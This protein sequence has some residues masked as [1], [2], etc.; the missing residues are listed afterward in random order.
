VAEQGGAALIIDYGHPRTAPGETL[1]AVRAH[2]YV[3]PLVDPGSSDLTHH[4]DFARLRQAAEAAGA[5]CWGPVAQ[6]LFF[7]RLGAVHRADKLAA[8]AADAV[9]A[10]RILS[11]VRRLLHPRSMGVLFQAMAVTS[12]EDAPPGF[13]SPT[14]AGRQIR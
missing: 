4:V 5:H 8:A 7:G 1:Q 3:D 10:E 13:S 11:A 2:R 9:Q 14:L 12:G 6:G